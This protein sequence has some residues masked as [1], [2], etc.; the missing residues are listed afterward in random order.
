MGSILP[1]TG[2]YFSYDRCFL[3]VFK[4]WLQCTSSVLHN[5][6]KTIDFVQSGPNFLGGRVLVW[7]ENKLQLLLWGAAGSKIS[8]FM[9]GRG[10]WSC[11]WLYKGIYLIE[12]PHWMTAARKS[13][14]CR[15]IVIVA[16][17]PFKL[18]SFGSFILF[19]YCH[20][21]SLRRRLFRRKLPWGH[22]ILLQYYHL[23]VEIYVYT[24]LQKY[25]SVDTLVTQGLIQ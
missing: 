15:A 16:F 8:E 19:G 11:R 14:S 25:S 10:L 7:S 20:Y 17:C 24:Y 12:Q 9:A 5:R 3:Q 13:W 18:F 2:H 23:R 6:K 1:W 4:F 22:C 21:C